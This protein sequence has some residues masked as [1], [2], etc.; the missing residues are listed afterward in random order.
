MCCC[1]YYLFCCCCCESGGRIT[2]HNFVQR[3]QKWIKIGHGTHGGNRVNE[4]PMSFLIR[5]YAH[6]KAAIKDLERV[7]VN[8]DFTSRFRSDLE[9]FIPQL[10]CF[11][12]KGD[13]EGEEDIVNLITLASTGSFFYSHRIWFFF[14]AML[15][16]ESDPTSREQHYKSRVVLRG[17]KDACIKS[18]E[19]LY[20]TNSQDI[21]KLIQEFSMTESYPWLDQMVKKNAKG[22]VLSS[23]DGK[24]ENAQRQ[25]KVRRRINIYTDNN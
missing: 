23:N 20:L 19:R 6:D 9:F 5:L 18:K 3:F 17:L 10:C 4:D 25:E 24:S 14:Q 16:P 11:Y 21:V 13:S 12:L 1:C 22:F 15:F 7:R 8:P 2:K